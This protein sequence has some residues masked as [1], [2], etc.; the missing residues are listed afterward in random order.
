[1]SSNIEDDYKVVRQT[2]IDK[3]NEASKLLKEANEL[4]SKANVSGSFGDYK[5]RNGA[6]YLHDLISAKYQIEREDREAKSEEYKSLVSLSDSLYSFYE[7]LDNSGWRTS[8][9]DC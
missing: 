9:F 4:V 2:I 6:E 7:V 8:S 1:M 3:V 5:L